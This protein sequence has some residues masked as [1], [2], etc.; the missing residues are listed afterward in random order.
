MKYG[1]CLIGSNPRNYAQLAQAAEAAGFESVWLPEHLFFPATMPAEYPYTDS[2]LPI[3]PSKT[4][5]YD[6]WIM[7]AAMGAATST[8]RLATNVYILPLRHPLMIARQLVTL[9]RISG[10]RVTL[11]AG[12]GWLRAEFDAVG[13]DFTKRGKIADEIIPLLRRL[14]SEEEIEHHGEFFDF[15]PI[16]FEPKP[17]QKVEGVKGI[18]IELGGA[19]PGALRRAGR[20]CDGWV[21]IGGDS[22]DQVAANIATINEHRQSAGRSHLPYEI[23]LGQALVQGPEQLAYARELGVTRLLAIPP[24]DMT[25]GGAPLDTALAFIEQMGRET[26][27]K[28]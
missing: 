9:D 13:V 19:S 7:L 28:P 8:I 27:G 23:T 17:I 6:P 12:V 18:P 24:F 15:P 16:N 11:G 2:G 22:L 26:I 14:W 5:L 1:F 3:T 21:E 4:P 20:L 25:T 10:G